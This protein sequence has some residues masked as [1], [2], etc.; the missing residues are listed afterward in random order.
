MS[1]LF[2]RYFFFKCGNIMSFHSL[3]VCWLPQLG[4]CAHSSG[5]L[6]NRAYRGVLFNPSKSSPVLKKCTGL[7]SIWYE[8]YIFIEKHCFSVKL[9]SIF[10]C[11][12][13]RTFLITKATTVK[14]QKVLGLYPME[15]TFG[16][17]V[18][19]MPKHLRLYFSLTQSE[20]NIS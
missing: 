10:S 12:L 18:I 7:L 9:T 3:G 1:W 16:L 14:E 15:K 13:F 8:W 2:S 4:N 11:R 17:W 20:L 6:L 5:L 19:L